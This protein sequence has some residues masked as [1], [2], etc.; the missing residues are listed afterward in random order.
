MIRV[1]TKIGDNVVV[2]P[3]SVLESCIIENNSFIGMGA[4]VR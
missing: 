4:T 2:G 3:N 1:A